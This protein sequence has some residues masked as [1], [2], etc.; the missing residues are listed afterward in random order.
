MR[1]ILLLTAAVLCGCAPAPAPV[2][3]SQADPT[4]EAWYPQAVGELTAMVRQA[5]RLL[6]GGKSAEAGDIVAMGQPLENRLLA[7]PRP[8]L[9]AMEAVSDLDQLY[10]RI[11]MGN[12]YYGSARML[13]QKNVVRWKNW[14]PATA[15]TQRRLKLALA[16][17][18]ECDRHLAE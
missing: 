6:A 10:G 7:A 16:A 8:T 11:L 5:E 13:F 2:E 18:A 4:A 15:D 14:K 1:P 9:A 3:R 12:H 17:I